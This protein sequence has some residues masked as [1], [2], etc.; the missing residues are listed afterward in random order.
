MKLLS[1]TT[2]SR[3]PV[4]VTDASLFCNARKRIPSF[5]S[6]LPFFT[7]EWFLWG[8]DVC[9]RVSK[10]GWVWTMDFLKIHNNLVLSFVLSLSLFSL[11]FSHSPFLSLFLPLFPFFPF[12]F[13]PFLPHL[14]FFFIPILTMNV[15]FIIFLLL[16]LK[17]RKK[18]VVSTPLV[19]SPMYTLR[20]SGN[21][22]NHS[23]DACKLQYMNK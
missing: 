10:E 16:K 8:P 17:H 13:P 22:D 4:L 6:S 20:H 12:S 11:S 14:F 18:D 9:K 19:M 5:F 15:W 23:R 3:D 7:K 21:S 1:V 2:K